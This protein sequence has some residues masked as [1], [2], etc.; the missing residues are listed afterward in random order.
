M[1]VEEKTKCQQSIK[2]IAE[3][4]VN[5]SIIVRLNITSDWGILLPRSATILIQNVGRNSKKQMPV[6]RTENQSKQSL[7]EFYDFLVSQSENWKIPKIVWLVWLIEGVKNSRI[8]YF[9]L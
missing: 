9:M 7:Q 6:I 5:M 4:A 1:L 3:I 2:I 8:K